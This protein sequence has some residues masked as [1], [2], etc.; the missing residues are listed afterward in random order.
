[1]SGSANKTVKLLN[2][3]E[4]DVDSRNSGEQQSLERLTFQES[5]ATA[6][7]VV[8]DFHSAAYG[9]SQNE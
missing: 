5:V 3:A 9:V 4:I 7:Q 1:M 6:S 8:S 2:A